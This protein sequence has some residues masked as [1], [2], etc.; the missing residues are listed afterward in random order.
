MPERLVMVSKLDV[1][2]LRTQARAALAGLGWRP[3]IAHAAVDAAVAAHGA[4]LTLTG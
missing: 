3:A 4:D 1:A 2:I